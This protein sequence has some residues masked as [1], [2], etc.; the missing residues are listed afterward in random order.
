MNGST[1]NCYIT[2]ALNHLEPKSIKFK[3][4]Q[5]DY[6]CCCCS[7]CLPEFISMRIFHLPKHIYKIPTK[8]Y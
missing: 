4:Q 6:Y 5:V 1:T 2:V 3:V 7:A 8:L